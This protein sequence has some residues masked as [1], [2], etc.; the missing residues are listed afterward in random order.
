[1]VVHRKKKQ[2]QRF[3][4]SK[5]THFVVANTMKHALEIYNNEAR[6]ELVYLLSLADAV[7]S[8]ESDNANIVMEK[9]FCVE[10][11]TWKKKNTLR[12]QPQGFIFFEENQARMLLW[13]K[14]I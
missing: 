7:L 1:M 11:R 13:V 8:F 5:S 9:C 14:C 2:R 6:T 3:L 4:L 10:V 12:L